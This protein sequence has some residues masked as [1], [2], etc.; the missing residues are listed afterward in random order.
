MSKGR[1]EQYARLLV[2]VGLN[3][4]QGQPLVISC[5]VDCAPFARLCAE[6]AYDAGASRVELDWQDDALTRLR[7]LRAD[8]AVFRRVPRRGGS[9]CGVDNVRAGA[10]FC[11]SMRRTPGRAQAAWTPG[12]SAA[13]T[14]PAGEALREFREATRQN[15]V[16]WCVASITVARLGARRVSG[17]A[18]RGGHVAL[19]GADFRGCARGAGR[20]CRRRLARAHRQADPL[21]RLAERA[22]PARVCTIETRWGPT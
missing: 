19:V 3:L 1:R 14:A 12:A 18:G 20:R 22:A 4:Q 6:A 15:R 13:P 21:P 11:P 17:A 16:Q 8:D 2:E 7:Y 10:R 9:R 5:P